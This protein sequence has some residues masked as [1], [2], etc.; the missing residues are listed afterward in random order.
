MYEEKDITDYRTTSQ[1]NADNVRR[2]KHVPKKMRKAKYTKQRSS[3][4]I[5]YR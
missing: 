4:A 2:T 5:S 3:N 1:R